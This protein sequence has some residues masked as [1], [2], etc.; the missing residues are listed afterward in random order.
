MLP[1]SAYK[2]KLYKLFLVIGIILSL[3]LGSL[4]CLLLLSSIQS[5]HLQSLTS[6]TKELENNAQTSMVVISKAIHGTMKDDALKAWGKSPDAAHMYFNAIS[7]CRSLQKIT[8][9]LTMVDYSLSV[10]LLDPPAFSNGEALSMVVSPEGTSLASHFFKQHASLEPAYVSDLYDYF[11]TNTKS[12]LLPCYD[13][14][15][16]LSSFC[17]VVKMQTEGIA[18]LYML[19]FPKETLAGNSQASHYMVYDSNGILACDS[20]PDSADISYGRLYELIY[21]KPPGTEKMQF[22][23]GNK[24]IFLA[25]IPST[26]WQIA[27]IYDGLALHSRQ[28]LLF[29]LCLTLL[30]AV[31][32]LFVVLL[33]EKLYKPVKEVILETISLE[34][35]KNPIDEFQL[36]RQNNEMLKTLGRSLSEATEE[37]HYLISQKAYQE[38]LFGSAATVLPNALPEPDALYCTALI[39]F[40]LPEAGTCPDYTEFGKNLVRDFTLG[41]KELHYVNTVHNRCAIIMQCEETEEA[42]AVLFHLLHSLDDSMSGYLYQEPRIALSRI[43]P[44]I[45]SLHQCYRENL[46][47]LEYRHLY[48]NSKILTFEQIA[49]IDAVN[50]SYS[51]S[52]E[53]RL[54]QN[55]IEGKPEA[56]EIFDSIIRENIRDKDLS[57]ETLQ[58]LVYALIGTL[59]RI[60][61]EL[62]ASP[63]EFIGKYIDFKYLYNHWNDSVTISA[64]RSSIMLITEAVQKQ[65]SSAEEKMLK[66]MREY[67]YANYSDD[68]MLNDMADYFNISPKYCGILFKQLSD[69]NFKDFLNRYRIEKAKEYLKEQPDIKIQDLC[70]MVGFNSSNSFTRVFS[71]YTGLTP[72]AYLERI[73]GKTDTHF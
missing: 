40:E 71:K 16:N 44:G 46:K 17:F 66:D 56:L 68:I 72:T 63:E 57:V 23:S 54:V 26:G 37:N 10:T 39:E 59:N 43:H 47:V 58:S 30:Q 35:L 5:E 38:L 33:T 36:I 67:I 64:L 28:I 11:Q 15:G 12:L 61:Q 52:T 21:T 1:R 41:K 7:L 45:H 60:F 32:L 2:K 19:T 14:T 27:Y 50:C 65:N 25:S 69:N 13:K 6:A 42:R 62:K 31:T 34:E 53:N 20:R 73:M 22:P 29:L 8:I 4:V 70:H 24:Q 9:D 3:I 49:A 48:A 51:L 18:Y 55:S